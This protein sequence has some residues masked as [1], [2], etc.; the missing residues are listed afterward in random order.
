[1]SDAQPHRPSTPSAAARFVSETFRKAS[2]N[3][4]VSRAIPASQVEKRRAR[5]EVR[6]ARARHCGR[7]P[8]ERENDHRSLSRG[9]GSQRSTA[10]GNEVGEE[11][12]SL[13][14]RDAFVS[15]EPAR[16]GDDRDRVLR[17]QRGVRAAG[18]RRAPRAGLVDGLNEA[19]GGANAALPAL[20]AFFK[21]Y[22]GNRILVTTRPAGPLGSERVDVPGFVTT[23]L[24]PM[25][26]EEVYRFIEQWCMAAEV[27]IQR[28]PQTIEPRLGAGRIKSS[29]GHKP[30]YLTLAI[31]GTSHGRSA[32]V[33]RSACAR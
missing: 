8:G 17:S 20:Q 19:P 33:P 25:V 22:P 7:C 5:A 29:I 16:R 9:D 10:P 12:G 13:R 27:S 1:M 3:Q 28:H 24:L 26:R 23:S 2:V 4:Q 30:A 14:R 31:L 11:P 32:R 18:A 15:W 6:Q 21:A